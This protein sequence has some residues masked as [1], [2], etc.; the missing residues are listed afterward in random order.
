MMQT[1]FPLSRLGDLTS[2]IGSGAT[3]RGGERAYRNDGVPLIRS[4]NVYDLRFERDGLAFIDDEQA[5]ALDHVMVARG[6]V[7]INIT[8]ASVARCCPAPQEL[9]GARVNQHVA[10]LRPRPELLDGRF[11]A[12]WLVAPDT[13]A[14]LLS[15]ARAGGTREALTKGGLQRF[16]V[17]APAIAVQRRIASILG[18]YDELIDVNRRRI[19]LLEEVSRRLF[20]EWFV[21]FRFPGHSERSLQEARRDYTPNGWKLM[22]LG[23][24]LSLTIGGTWGTDVADQENTCAV[25]IVR[26]TDFPGLRE[27]NL[28]TVPRRFV[29]PRVLAKRKLSPRDVVME[30]SGGSKDQP[31]G[32]VIF[33]TQS[34]IGAFVDPVTLASFCRLLRVNDE[35]AS[36]YQVFWH[37]DRVYRT[38][39]IETYQTQS[40]GIRNLKL[41][42]MAENEVLC[43][44]PPEIRA[45]FEEIIQPAMD[46]LAVHSVQISA[47]Q[48][49]R[50][51]IL[52]RLISGELSTTAA[53]RELETVA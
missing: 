8:G 46:A 6:D 26:G 28:H 45:A 33:A 2:K 7:L 39:F 3:P 36:P 19:R 23:S 52:P 17:P 14:L 9:A 27:G 51:F 16:M 1:I 24:V 42:V 5:A 29:S 12:Y 47:L 20:E 43:L 25:S 10:I 37:L 13:K 32:R 50:D 38:G 30:V 11:L 49:S 15:I 53:E 48:R 4:M 31:V 18:A 35:L 22:P 44:P 40:T 34:L 41:G 21:R